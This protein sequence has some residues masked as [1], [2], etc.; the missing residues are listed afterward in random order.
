[1][2]SDERCWQLGLAGDLERNEQSWNQCRRCE[3]GTQGS[4]GYGEVMQQGARRISEFQV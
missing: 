2:A 4:I 1:M 3:D